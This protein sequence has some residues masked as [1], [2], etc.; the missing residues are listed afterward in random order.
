M[1]MA[2]PMKCLSAFKEQN[3]EKARLYQGD[4]EMDYFRFLAKVQKTAKDNL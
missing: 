2:N 3:K 4:L 1:S